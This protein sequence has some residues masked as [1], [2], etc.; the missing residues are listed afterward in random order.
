M[1]RTLLPRSA[2]RLHVPDPVCVRLTLLAWPGQGRRPLPRR[3]LRSIPRRSTARIDSTVRGVLPANGGIESDGGPVSASGSCSP[4]CSPRRCSSLRERWARSSGSSACRSQGSDG[5]SERAAGAPG[6][7]RARVRRGNRSARD[8]DHGVAAARAVLRIL[9][10]RLGEPHRHRA[11]RARARLLARRTRR[12][13]AARAVAPRAHR[14]RRGRVRGRDP[15]RGEAVPRPH[16]RGARRGFGG[17]GDRELPRR[18][19]A[20]RAARRAARDGLAVRDPAR[21][22]EHRDRRGGRRE[23]V[24]PLDRGLA[25][26]HVPAGSRPDPRGR[27][28]A[29]VPRH[30]RSARALVVLSPR[31]PLSRRRRRARRLSS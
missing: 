14:P 2:V 11:R 28:A 25:D 27:D 20:L 21:G 5:R 13:P 1:T 3:R 24:R 8:R 12:R 17:G 6:A 26:R 16:R 4:S 10:H 29:D 30:R 19:A 22:D 18:S 15:V 9:H 23:A 7:R 31:R